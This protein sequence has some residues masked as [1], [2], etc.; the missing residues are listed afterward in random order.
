[1][2][3]NTANQLLKIVRENYQAIAGEFSQT[4]H[5]RLWPTLAGLAARVPAGSSVLDVGCGNGRLRQAWQGQAVHYVGVEQSQRLLDLAQR[6]ER[7]RLDGQA[8]Y[9]GNILELGRLGLAPFDFVFCVAVLHHLPGQALREQ[10]LTQLASQVKAGGYLVLSVWA[11]WQQ[12]KYRQLLL[13]SIWDKLRGRH[14][15]DFGDLLF[16]WGG[17]AGSQRYYH[18]FTRRELKALAKRSGLNFESIINDGHSWYLV[19]RRE[20]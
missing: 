20:F 11:L 1:M 12:P 8:F 16:G 15:L 13:R 17:P 14:R 2:D 9:L 6:E 10:G 3:Q 18:A 5:K 19:L 7:Y 4:R